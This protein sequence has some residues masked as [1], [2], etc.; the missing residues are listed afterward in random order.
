V[1]YAWIPAA[2]RV[3][4]VEAGIVALIAPLLVVGRASRRGK[5]T[6]AGVG[7]A[8][9]RVL[10][11]LASTAVLVLLGV[12][13]WQA[14]P[15]DLSERARLWLSLVGGLLYF[16]AVGLY[17][18]GFQTLG[19]VLRVSSAFAA[20]LPPDHEIVD[21]GPYRLV[22]HP[23]Y[24]GVILAAA[25][26]LLIFRT[27]AMVVFFPLSFVVL[28]RARREEEAL[29]RRHGATWESYARTVAAWVPRLR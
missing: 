23:M 16:P 24:L 27:W 3:V 8:S 5:A 17:L 10:R 12:I 18:W 19:S 20:T 13:L 28:A 11:P 29:G 26:A 15:L 14:I 21:R 1:T 22:R 4:A 25:G 6:E 7:D 2:I 9:A